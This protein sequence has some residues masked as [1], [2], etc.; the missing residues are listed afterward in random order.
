[1]QIVK[2][3]ADGRTVGQ[4][5]GRIVEGLHR[6]KRDASGSRWRCTDESCNSIGDYAHQTA[7]GVQ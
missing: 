3:D 6:V 1:M 7:I 5:V 4:I 2:R